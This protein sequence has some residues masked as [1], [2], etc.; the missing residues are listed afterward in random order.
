MGDFSIGRAWAL[1]IQFIRKSPSGHAILLILMASAAPALIQFALVGDAAMM[2]PA[3]FQSG[4]GAAALIGGSL[5]TVAAM[6]AGYVLTTGGYFASWRL[7]LNRDAELG[8]A[9]TYGLFA[10]LAVVGAFFAIG[11]VGYALVQVLGWFGGLLALLIAMPLFIAFYSV[12]F[13][14]MGIGMVLM[15]LFM[16]LFGAAAGSMNPAMGG[17]G[18]GVAGAGAVIMV[19]LGL[20]FLWLAARF[21]CA[22]PAMASR[23]SLDF[24]E[25]V[26]E[27]WHVTAP[28]QGRIM[29][30]LAL[31]GLLIGLVYLIFAGVFAAA[32]GVSLAG[33][34]AP[35][36]GFGAVLLTIVM[37]MA[38]AYVS[39]LIPAGI[40]RAV[41][42]DV[43]ASAAVFE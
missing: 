43:D 23:G 5:A 33:G 35:S 27:S 42:P 2:N 18:A 16:L 21:C 3:A 26:R 29:L 25:G 22:T 32:V 30:Y 12:L 31:V 24:L 15:G 38:L 39:V 19:P 7:G 8:G 14:M 11:L 6:V 36:I 4:A 10:G 9:V 34:G 37:G 40:Y 20:L 28:R 41:Q 17:Y 1:G 13:G